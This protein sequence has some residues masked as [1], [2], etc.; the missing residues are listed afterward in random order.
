MQ[1]SLLLAI[2]AAGSLGAVSRYLLG[3]LVLDC[4]PGLPL[5][6]FVVN[7]LGCFGFGLCWSLAA[8]R[9]SPQVTAAVLVGFFGAFTTFSAF[10]FDCHALLSERR[11]LVLL[12]DVVAQ[13]VLGVLALAAGIAL[14]TAFGRS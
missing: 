12:I 9:W 3:N 1:A 13:N 5:H 2:A 11:Y 7:V 8:G 14:A 10:A 4:C 6:T